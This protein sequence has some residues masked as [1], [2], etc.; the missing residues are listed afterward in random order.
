MHLK[1]PPQYQQPVDDGW[2]KLLQK[3]RTAV[4]PAL[5]GR[6]TR[7]LRT[8]KSK[9][10]LIVEDDIDSVR[11]LSLL[12]AEMGHEVEYAINGYVA[13]D[14]ARRF[15]PEIVLLDIG[16]PGLDGFDVCRAVKNQPDLKDTRVIV[17]TGYSQPEFRERSVAAGCELHLVKPVDPNALQDI[18]ANY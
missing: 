11:T 8:K 18:L 6:S 17:I 15:R 5:T 3:V 4:T 12:V 13:I 9:R 2:R 16:L 10:V 7:H 1:V 14:L